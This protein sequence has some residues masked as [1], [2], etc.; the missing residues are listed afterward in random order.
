MSAIPEAKPK[1]MQTR[2]RLSNQA[3][4]DVGYISNDIEKMEEAGVFR[5][6]TTVDEMIATKAEVKRQETI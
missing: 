1:K 4:D 2:V 5:G 3:D 6:P